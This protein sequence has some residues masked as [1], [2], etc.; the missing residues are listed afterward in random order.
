[1]LELNPQSLGHILLHMNKLYLGVEN[2]SHLHMP[3]SLA[4]LPSFFFIIII[5]KIIHYVILLEIEKLKKLF[6]AKRSRIK[7]SYLEKT[8]P[9]RSHST[10]AAMQWKLGPKYILWLWN[11]WTALLALFPGDV[12]YNLRTILLR[13]KDPKSYCKVESAKNVNGL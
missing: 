4:L 1:M 13:N 2:A 12:S 6:F 3:I 10:V 11:Q 5:E 7:K 9:Q 8:P